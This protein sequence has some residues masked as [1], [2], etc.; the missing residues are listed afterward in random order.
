MIIV[1]TAVQTVFDTC[2]SILGK[3]MLWTLPFHTSI[4]NENFYIFN[5]LSC[6]SDS[7]F[8]ILV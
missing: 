2:Y 1:N 3:G 6:C 8:D 7:N 4:K 5:T